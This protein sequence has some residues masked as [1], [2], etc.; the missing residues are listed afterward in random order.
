V[1]IYTQQTKIVVLTI[2][3][4]KATMVIVVIIIHIVVKTEIVTTTILVC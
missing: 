3:L 1:L 4:V 2:S